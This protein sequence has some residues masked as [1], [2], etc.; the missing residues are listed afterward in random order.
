MKNKKSKMRAA[1]FGFA[2]CALNFGLFAFAQEAGQK[3]EIAGLA[4]Y[5]RAMSRYQRL[6]ELE[7]TQN[8]EEYFSRGSAYREEILQS[9]QAAIAASQPQEAVYL[10][11]RLLLWRFHRDQQDDTQEAALKEL[12]AAAEEYAKS[13][14]DP[15]ALKGAADALVSYKENAPARQLYA[16]YVGKFASA[17]IKD[18][19]LRARAEEAYQ[20][21]NAQLSEA[22]YDV[23]LGRLAKEKKAAALEEVARLFSYNDRGISDTAYAE[24]IFQELEKLSGKNAFSEELGY[25][26]AYNCEKAKDYAKAR[27]AYSEF[28]RRFPDSAQA[29]KVSYK[30]GI[31][32]AYALRDS[33]GAKPY[34]EKLSAAKNP[35]AYSASALYQLGLLAQWQGQND[36]AKGCY[37]KIKEKAME[38]FGDLAALGD[39]RLKEIAEEKPIEYNLKSFLDLALAAEQPADDMSKAALKSSPSRVKINAPVNFQGSA[40]LP[41][42][43]C[44]QQEAQ[45]LWSGDLGNAKP[46]SDEPSFTTAYGYPGVKV[47]NL[48]IVSSTGVLDRSLE[49]VE[50]E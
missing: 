22:L 2:F 46:S 26:R 32:L 6:K 28:L 45:Y 19:D 41:E 1:L 33:A 40:F 44:L 27:D 7:E 47:L 13:A 4:D 49:M 39:E 48:V 24:N 43:G 50:A 15:A 9:A 31:I 25:L 16:L 37:Q 42:S 35:S 3:K 8:W 20:Q 36:Q 29:Q 14:K 17:E 38:G 23:Y 5:N 21:G 10:D 11:S 18:E 34:F 12:L 30:L